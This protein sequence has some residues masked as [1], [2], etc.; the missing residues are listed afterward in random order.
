M[1]TLA[2]IRDL[3]VVHG[4]GGVVCGYQSLP[5]FCSR[6]VI[7]HPWL[8]V[9]LPLITCFVRL[10]WAWWWVWGDLGATSFAGASS[11]KVYLE[12]A[13]WRPIAACGEMT[14]V[15]ADDDTVEQLA[16]RFHITAA[17]IVRLNRGRIRGLTPRVQMKEGTQLLVPQDAMVN[18]PVGVQLEKSSFHVQNPAKGKGKGKVRLA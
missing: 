4:D 1:P 11:E 16:A 2:V 13:R 18:N 8:L 14:F 15:A 6:F 7:A 12:N 3:N 10:M 5:N 9:V 17:E